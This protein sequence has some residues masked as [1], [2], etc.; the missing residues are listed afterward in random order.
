MAYQDAPIEP[1]IVELAEHAAKTIRGLNHLTRGPHAFA[2]PAELSRLLAELTVMT[3]GLPQL[4]NQLH[5]WLCHEHDAARLKADTDTDQLVRLAAV[6]LTHAGHTA[7]HLTAALDAA[8]QHAAHLATASPARHQTEERSNNRTK[9]VNF[10]PGGFERRSQHLL[11]S[12]GCVVVASSCQEGA[13]AA[14]A[15]GQAPAVPAVAGAGLEH[16]VRGPRGWG[17]PGLG[18]QVVHRL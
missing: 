7:H 12:G 16:P 18:E 3:S 8:H 11:Q 9:G 14:S 5:N 1:S 13:G 4:L 15:V 10:R 2:E 17:V 6:E